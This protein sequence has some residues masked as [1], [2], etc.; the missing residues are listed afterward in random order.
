[1]SPIKL[2][3]KQTRFINEY[4]IDGNG[5]AAA[6][7]AGYGVAGAKVTACRLLT[8]P[9]LQEALQARQAADATR[10]CL[11]REDVLAGVQEAINQAREQGN[12]AAMISGWREIAKMLGFYAVETKRVEISTV[13]QGVSGRMELM[14]D[15]ELL[16]IIGAGQTPT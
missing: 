10:L 13:G 5:A 12:P 6:V 15:A 2:T 9:N 1:M 14:S 16:E 7:R 3:A 8:N 11:Q 4:L